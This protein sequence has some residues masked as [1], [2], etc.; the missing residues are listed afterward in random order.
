MTAVSVDATMHQVA[1][2][3]VPVA[4]VFERLA[5]PG[6]ISSDWSDLRQAE[7]AV[8]KPRRLPS[9]QFLQLGRSTT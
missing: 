8:A 1:A 6:A 9:R 4:P 5:F 2:I 7:R 3:A